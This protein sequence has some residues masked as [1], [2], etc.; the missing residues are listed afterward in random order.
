MVETKKP[1][2]MIEATQFT[3]EEF[4]KQTAAGAAPLTNEFKKSAIEKLAGMVKDTKSELNTQMG[5]LKNVR[6]VR[7]LKNANITDDTATKPEN[8]VLVFDLLTSALNIPIRARHEAPKPM[9]HKNAVKVPIFHVFLEVLS[10]INAM[11]LKALE[12]SQAQGYDEL[13]QMQLHVAKDLVLM[14]QTQLSFQRAREMIHSTM[15]AL[16]KREDGAHIHLFD[17]L[18]YI[19][20]MMYIAS[21]E[22]AVGPARFTE[23]SKAVQAEIAKTKPHDKKPRNGKYQ[24]QG[25]ETRHNKPVVVAKPQTPPQ[26]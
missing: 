13:Y 9:V 2:K 5:G 10:R 19:Q 8:I 26:N 11:T 22:S 15:R 21:V 16:V 7:V 25:K 18:D 6:R 1:A 4:E 3:K 24:H 17:T 20:A 14:E 12:L 23:L